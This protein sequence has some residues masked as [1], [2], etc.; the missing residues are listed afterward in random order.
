MAFGTFRS[1]Q[2]TLADYESPNRPTEGS[3]RSR[4]SDRSTHTLQQLGLCSRRS[5]RLEGCA[6]RPPIAISFN[7]GRSGGAGDARP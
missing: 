6:A 3:I 1:K 4:P 5:L 2:L 7:V